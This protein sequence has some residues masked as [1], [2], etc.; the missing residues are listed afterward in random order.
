[1]I[2]EVAEHMKIGFIGAGK[3]GVSLGK[4]FSIHGVSISGYASRHESSAKEAAQFTN[5][6]VYSQYVDLIADSDM[7]FLTVTDGAI[8]S[9]W[10]SIK[11]LPIT[12]KDKIFC[13]CSGSLSSGIFS[14]IEQYGA[15]GYSLHPLFAIHSKQTS[16]KD[17]SKTLFTLEGNQKH[18]PDIKALIEGLGNRV[19]IIP[20]EA[21]TKYHAA[22]VFASNHVVA[23]AKVSIDLLQECGFSS[24]DA[25][26]AIT[27]LITGNVAHITETGPNGA[28]TGPVERNDVTT[29]EKHISCLS[30]D[31]EKLY[32]ELTKVLISIG[33]EKH[34]DEDYGPMTGIVR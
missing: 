1:M 2:T 12:I 6:N 32:K 33:Q 16:Y 34:P 8:A 17:L 13:H 29:V 5:S 23:L 14:E 4:Y 25:L 10:D 3:V 26:S 15:F 22:A 11:E 9:V 7:I 20:T 21:K 24:E 30:G 27:P 31:Y 19:Q 28:L 18:L